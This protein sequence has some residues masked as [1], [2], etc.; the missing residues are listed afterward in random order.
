MLVQSVSRLPNNLVDMFSSCKISDWH[1]NIEKFKWIGS[2]G[3][4]FLYASCYELLFTNLL[5]LKISL[6]KIQRHDIDK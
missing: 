4:R 6:V 2:L 5:G 1:K 3:V